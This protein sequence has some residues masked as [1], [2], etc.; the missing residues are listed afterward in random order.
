[1]GVSGSDLH[2][3]KIIGLF[4]ERPARG[5]LGGSGGHSRERQW[6]LALVCRRGRGHKWPDPGGAVGM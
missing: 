3:L 4:C 6:W 1:M 5:Q 2:F